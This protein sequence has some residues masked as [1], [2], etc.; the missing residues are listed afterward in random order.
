MTEADALP[1][2]GLML[3]AKAVAA[4]VHARG[5]KCRE[6]VDFYFDAMAKAD[7]TKK[8]PGIENVFFRFD[9]KGPDMTAE[10]RRA[11]YE[12][13]ILAKAF[14]DLMRGVRAS[15]EQAYL[16]TELILHP[17]RQTKSDST[18]DDLI[19]PLLK[20]AADLNF[21]G[22]LAKVNSRLDAPLNFA[23]A[24]RSMQKARNCFEHR[25][26]IVGKSDVGGV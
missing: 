16:F 8:P 22:L 3:D 21:P 2:L 24:Y 6:V 12:S 5:V 26:V 4:P 20:E 17:R 19:A 7:L 25:G 15:L 13:W 23:P 11:L 1:S 18:L 9:V 14:Q 10:S